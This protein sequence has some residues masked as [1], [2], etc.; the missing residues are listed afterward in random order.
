MQ[1]VRRPLAPQETDY[2]FIWLLVC[3]G[4]FTY[5]ATWLVWK[6]PWPVCLFH[7]LTDRPCATCGATRAGIALVHGQFGA[8]WKWNPLAFVSYLAIIIFSTYA[9]TVVIM[10]AP[11]LRLIRVTPAEKK[12][13]RVSA[14]ALLLAN[15]IYLLVWNSAF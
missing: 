11:R 2:E 12:F 7:A 4:T 1:L 3:A 8:A 5:V 9:F 10:R 14:V 13:L 15:W 6:L